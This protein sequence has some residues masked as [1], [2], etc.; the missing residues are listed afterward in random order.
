MSNP[1]LRQYAELRK[2]DFERHPIWMCVY[3]IDTDEP[4]YAG[5]NELTYRPWPSSLPYECGRADG[6]M[7]LA[8]TRLTLADGTELDGF[9]S[10]PF[11]PDGE[12][13]SSL[14]YRQ[15]QLFLPDGTL[16]GF[17]LGM[18]DDAATESQRLYSALQKRSTQVFPIRYRIP[19]TIIDCNNTAII[20]GFMRIGPDMKTTITER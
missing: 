18:R 19:N 20:E 11:P 7:V 3:G 4:W 17:W 5:A 13:G 12:A 2:S 8:H 16:I 10:P 14:S 15:P 9:S 1:F 6:P